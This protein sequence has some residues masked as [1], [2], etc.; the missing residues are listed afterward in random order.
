MLFCRR[1][2]DM[3]EPHELTVKERREQL[4]FGAFAQ[5]CGL[6][7]EAASITSCKPQKPDIRCTL[8]GQE[9]FFELAE[10]VP[11]ERAKDLSKGSSSYIVTLQGDTVGE[12]AMVGIIRKKQE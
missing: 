8:G 9:Y 3:C 11:E 1:I 10:V 4:V 2:L 5:R 6:N 7:I 12:E